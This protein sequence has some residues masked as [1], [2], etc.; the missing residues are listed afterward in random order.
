MRTHRAIA[1]RCL[2]RSPRVMRTTRT[3]LATRSRS[4][5]VVDDDKALVRSPPK[6]VASSRPATTSTKRSPNRRF[7]GAVNAASSSMQSAI[8]HSKYALP[9]ASRRSS[10]SSGIVSANVRDTPPRA[11]LWYARSPRR[12]LSPGSPS[13]IPANATAP[14][15][16]PGSGFTSVRGVA[17]QPFPPVRR[18]AP[19]APRATVGLRR[20]LPPQPAA[21]CI[22][23]T[24][25]TASP[26]CGHRHLHA[27]QY[28]ARNAKHQVEARRKHALSS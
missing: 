9:T 8:R 1:W 20:P 19:T 21:G 2:L 4:L 10:G 14:Q 11:A 23:T 3:V 12:V 16:S 17:I 15:N 5:P 24:A 26:K 13:G 28:G 25:P 22:G 6:A 7:S 27:Q 18:C